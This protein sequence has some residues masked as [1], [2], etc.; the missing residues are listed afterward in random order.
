MESLFQMIT[1][2]VFNANVPLYLIALIGAW[3]LI[4]WTYDN[5]KSVIQ[6]IKS[7]LTPYFQ[8]NENKGF[9]EKYG[10]W[11]VITGATDGIGK[12]YSKELAKHGMN[13][14]LISRTE[15]KLIEVAKEIESMYSV[16]TKYVAVDFGN[17]KEIYEKIKEELK[18]MDIGVLVNNVG[19]MYDFP[20]DLDHISEE[21]LWQIININI[22]AVTM[23]S[24][25][26][27]PQMKANQR[28]MIVNISSGSECQP[29]PLMT[30]YAS[31]K[32]Y[33]RNFTLALR[34]ELEEHNVQVQL[35][36]PMFVQTKM[37]NYST[38]VMKGSILVP[39][40]ES[41]TRSAVFTLGKSS[42]TNGYWSHGL[43]YGCM[44]LVPEFIRTCVSFRMNKKFRDEYYAQQTI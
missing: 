7:I 42:Q 35:V 40:V 5:F 21:L 15:S 22:G 23:M 13:I 27:I 28:G 1:N 4:W 2:V 39:D 11:A 32:V 34:K 37:N 12:Q 14:V 24:R 26:F 6:I 29:T 43:Q 31:S 38:S 44:K 3:A 41:Y 33:I 8:P 17:G 9:V 36:T 25:I 18:S 20:D 16:K 10:K 30:V 19:R